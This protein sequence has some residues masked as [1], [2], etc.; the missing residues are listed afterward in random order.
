[1]ERDF[2]DLGILIIALVMFALSIFGKEEI[3]N[4]CLVIGWGLLIFHWAVY[5]WEYSIK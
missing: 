5:K 3:K 4:K 2:M 1:M